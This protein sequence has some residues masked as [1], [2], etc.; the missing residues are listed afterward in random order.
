MVGFETHPKSLTRVEVKDIG[1]HSSLS[2]LHLN[3]YHKK[4]S[5]LM[6][7]SQTQPQVLD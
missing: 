7:G 5:P 3:Y 1:E 6:V 2:C 4:Y